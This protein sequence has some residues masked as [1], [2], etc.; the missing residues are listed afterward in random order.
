MMTVSITEKSRNFNVC[1]GVKS[2]GTIEGQRGS[3][4]SFSIAAPGSTVRP[5]HGFHSTLRR[6]MQAILV[7]NGFGKSGPGYKTR[8]TKVA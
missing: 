3:F 5:Y 7:A 1:V 6:A 8:F 4:L 2:I